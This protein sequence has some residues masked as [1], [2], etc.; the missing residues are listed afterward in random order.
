MLGKL[1]LGAGAVVAAVVALK[2]L[3]A[4]LGVVLGLFGMV[5]GLAMFVLFTVVPLALLA[6]LAYVLVQ[7]IRRPRSELA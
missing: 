3:K 1:M 6:W 7:K 5:F 2:V 4:V